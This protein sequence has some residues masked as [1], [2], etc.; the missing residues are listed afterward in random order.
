LW[1]Q[2]AIQR[3]LKN[4]GLEIGN[5]MELRRQCRY[6]WKMCRPTLTIST[7]MECR[8]IGISIM[9]SVPAGYGGFRSPINR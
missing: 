5:H 3:F 2:Q 8:A 4:V 1:H 6:N 9:T 7:G